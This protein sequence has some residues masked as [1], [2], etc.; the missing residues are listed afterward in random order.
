MLVLLVTTISCAQKASTT[1]PVSTTAPAPAKTTAATAV[2]ATTPQYG[3][4]LK[5]VVAGGGPTNM[6]LP[7]QPMMPN[8]AVQRPAC[9]RL[10]GMDKQ[11]NPTPQL[12]T[13]WQ[14]NPD[15]KSITYTLRKGVK[16]HDGTDFNAAAVKYCLELWKSGTSVD[17]KAV[18]SIDVIDDYTVQ[19]NF[20]APYDPAFFPVMASTV[21]I[22]FSPTS[23]QKL[24]NDAKTQPVGTGPFK[25]ASFQRDVSLK[26]ERFDG[27]WGGKP[28]LD[29]IE[30]D[31]IADQV[32]ALVSFKTGEAQT[33]TSLAPKDIN[34][35]KVT[36]KYN[37][38]K[39][40]T[41]V[42]GAVGDSAHSNSPFAD[43]KVRQ[44]IAYAI[45]NA[46]I[47]KSLGHGIWEATNQLAPPG[48]YAYNN[49][50]VGYPYNPQKAKDLLTQAGYPK[51]FQT[52]ITFQA[53]S[54]TQDFYTM[55]QGY[56]SAVG[57]DLTLDS[58]DA[59][60][61]VQTQ[62][63]GW[64]NQL[65][66]FNMPGSVGYDPGTGLSSRISS[67]ASSYTPKSL[68]T[69]DDYNTQLT[70][71]KTE[72]DPAKRKAMFQDLQKM[73]IDQYCLAFPVY[74]G[75]SAAVSSLQ[76]HDLELLEYAMIEWHPEKAWL[77]K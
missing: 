19:L 68:Y 76:V 54:T 41:A 71:A 37:V 63:G 69:P 73:I 55:V 15:H 20:S 50:V 5:I 53:S 70:Q 34:D 23:L 49:A 40:P 36:G 64:N 28:Y 43:I 1:T 24:G 45:D 16:F 47:V 33:I 51:G 31:F 52:K 59:G 65:V 62:T 60:R 17:L 9:E 7:G 30:Y 22:I 42:F 57:I 46:A 75:Y 13:S 4:M 8:D 12:A 56:F 11:G 32:T 44:A 74:A 3:G 18:T 77:S 66:D 29:G 21:S 6:G 10:V 25:F 27:Y 38:K 61:F 39:T 48:G 58:A 14:S 67:K 2:P 72:L 35:L 26:Y